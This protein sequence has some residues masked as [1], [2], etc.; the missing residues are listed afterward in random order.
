VEIAAD[1]VVLIHYTLK[2][3]DGTVLDSS[4]GGEPLA[5]IQGHGN[6]VPGLEKALEGKQD[7]NKLAVT[8][9]PDEGYGKRSDE[10]VQRVPKR[11]LQGAGDIRKG[12]QFRAQTGEGL[13]VF[14]VTAVVGD[15]VT[16]DG[17]HPLADH[18]LHFD[19]EV[20]GVRSATAEELEH[21]HVHGAG[22]HH[23]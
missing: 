17:N 20:I 5:Y 4:A 3:D 8:L 19:V 11:S 2:G 22:G 23:H 6:L 10:L 1:T 13:R 21:G 15:M 16:L 14:T 7:G 12:M 18:T 9:S